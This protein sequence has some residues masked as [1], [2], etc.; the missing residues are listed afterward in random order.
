M[1]AAGRKFFISYARGDRAFA[2]RLTG[3][4][5]KEGAET[6]RDE[7]DIQSAEKWDQSIVKGIGSCPE[8]LIILSRRS[9]D[10]EFVL[11][12]LD[13][14]IEQNKRIVPVLRNTCKL[15][16]DIRRR[17]FSD[18]RGS[19]KTGLAHLLR[20]PPPVLTWWEKLWVRLCRLPWL[21]PFTSALGV[22]ILL[23]AVAIWWWL[24]L[25]SRTT[26]RV[27]ESSP[28]AI[29]LQV[30]NDGG[31]S[32]QLLGG[33]HWLRF[34]ELPIEDQELVL[35]DPA[36][37]SRVSGHEEA[38]VQLTAPGLVPRPNADGTYI[39]KDKLLV[40]L[41]EKQVTLESLIAESHGEEKRSTR[42]AAEIIQP[43]IAK[44]YPDALP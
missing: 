13:C 19:Y 35:V 39:A 3:D 30:R 1:K 31:R 34:G 41:K 4:L 33:G 16:L 37:M 29:L 22:F 14:A 5:R 44:Q 32:S 38:S 26:V 42:F 24:L 8:F 27:T 7:N 12:E 18:F 28:S 2:L 17:Q 15:P 40:L 20:N 6:W 10:S 9:V 25:P 43:F 36:A 11:K 21:R 23:A